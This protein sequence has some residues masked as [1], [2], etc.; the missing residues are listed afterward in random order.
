VWQQVEQYIKGFPF[1]YD[2]SSVPLPVDGLVPQP[3]IASVDGFQCW[4]CS[5]KTQDRSNAGK[6]ASQAHNKKR[7]KDEGLFQS[8]KLQS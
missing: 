3:I 1:E 8:V 6:H 7:V 5:F 4:D 2:Y